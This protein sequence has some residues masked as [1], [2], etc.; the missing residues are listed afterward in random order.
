[1]I[2]IN[3]IEILELEGYSVGEIDSLLIKKAKRKLFADIEL[4]DDNTFSYKGI[5]L[6]KTDCESAIEKL[7]K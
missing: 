7:E 5:P 2:F 6:T 4:S 1:M 3:P